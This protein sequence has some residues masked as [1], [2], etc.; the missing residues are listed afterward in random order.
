MGGQIRIKDLPIGKNKETRTIATHPVFWFVNMLTTFKKM[1]KTFNQVP[2]PNVSIRLLKLLRIDL[3]HR[4]VLHWGKPGNHV[5]SKKVLKI[6]HVKFKTNKPVWVSC[7]WAPG[8]MLRGAQKWPANSKNIQEIS[9]T[10]SLE[11]WLRGPLLNVTAQKRLTYWIQWIWQKV[12]Y[13][14]VRQKNKIRI[15]SY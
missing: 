9:Y 8:E 3:N 14:F 12:S 2:F 11:F 10:K 4:Q 13:T 7:S 5:N 1:I 6:V 15:N